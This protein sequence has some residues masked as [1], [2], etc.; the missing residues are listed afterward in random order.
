MEQCISGGLAPSHPI[1]TVSHLNSHLLRA[2]GER[3]Y[4]NPGDRHVS[5]GGL[6]LGQRALKLSVFVAGVSS[7]CI[8]LT[9]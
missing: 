2:N 8:F 5:L 7:R 1:Q 4:G 6:E 9:F 3:A